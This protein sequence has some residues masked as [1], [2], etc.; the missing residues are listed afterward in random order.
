MPDPIAMI[1][2]LTGNILDCSL[3]KFLEF[4][5]WAI[6]DSHEKNYF[7]PKLE[8]YYR[9]VENFD[10]VYVFASEDC[11]VHAT[12]RFAKGAMTVEDKAA[13]TWNIKIVFKDVGAFWKFMISGGDGVVE[14]MQANE[15]QVFGNLNYLY[16]FGFLT[17]D[18]VF[19]RLGIGLPDI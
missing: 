8:G 12:A 11:S 1:K 15:V 2:W 5:A 13:D 6:E 7:I 3:E 16:K 19:E 18:L 17:N 14:A 10:A 4:M 9:N